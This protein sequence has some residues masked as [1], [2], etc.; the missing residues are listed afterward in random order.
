MDA[1]KLARLKE[2]ADVP[3]ITPYLD[4]RFA[5][6]SPSAGAAVWALWVG[7][8][9]PDWNTGVVLAVILVA[10]PLAL[11]VLDDPR[12]G[13]MTPAIPWL[14][15][16][17]PPAGLLA[18]VSVLVGPGFVSALLSLPWLAC[19]G[20]IAV[21]GVFRLLSRRALSDSAIGVDLGLIGLGLAGLWF[22]VNRCGGETE[23]SQST[24]YLHLFGFGAPFVVGCS[25]RRLGSDSLLSMIA[26][27]GSILAAL[28]STV[29][30]RLDVVASGVLLGVSVVVSKQLLATGKAEHRAAASL[31]GIAGACLIASS[32]LS[33]VRLLLISVDPRTFA[34]S[35]F[36]PDA[37]VTDAFSV[38]YATLDAPT[39]GAVAGLS[40]V[41]LLSALL[42]LTWEASGVDGNVRATLVHLVPR[43]D[44]D[45]LDLL[46]YSVTLPAGEFVGADD[47][48]PPAGYLWGQWSLPVPNFDNSCDAL[49]GW[50]GHEAASV[51]LRP[52]QPQI[53]VG[54]TFVMAVPVGPLTFSVACRISN[55]VDES[56]RY[57]FAYTTLSNHV[58]EGSES[59]IVSRDPD[60]SSVVTATICWRPTSVAAG[61]LPRLTAAVQAR[62]VNTCL[63]G[64]AAAESA[65]VGDYLST[66]VEEVASRKMEVSRQSLVQKP[67]APLPQVRM[68]PDVPVDPNAF[69][70][71]VFNADQF[72]VDQF[73]V[74]MF[75]ADTSEAE[76]SEAETLEEFSTGLFTPL[77]M[78]SRPTDPPAEEP[79]A[80]LSFDEVFSEPFDAPDLGNT[81]EF[82]SSSSVE[83]RQ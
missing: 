41:F 44:S 7:T 32:V 18:L 42:A 25:A 55:I 4:G 52:D 29:D 20:A 48:G 40:L 31:L 38:T 2:N 13:P 76:E 70:P 77:G 58:W 9:R 53:A 39:I 35:V 51:R 14:R 80:K 68:E 36:Q 61:A 63:G 49:L 19:A 3:D 62:A 79:P 78:T 83:E 50:A 82:E 73:Q 59:F 45:L 21:T 28:L 54:E 46:R 37:V 43:S 75:D 5:T 27:G 33:L 6:L 16:V 81:V 56:D 64:I 10:V 57:G 72:Q 15:L 24:A 12:N 34:D 74:G 60:G 17:S 30:G 23:L 69:D 22:F 65:L 67:V 8:A 66:I 71:D 47:D 1:A 26:S 11:Q